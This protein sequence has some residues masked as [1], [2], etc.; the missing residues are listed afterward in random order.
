MTETPQAADEV[1]AR[2]PG[3]FK[4]RKAAFFTLRAADVQWHRVCDDLSGVVILPMM[5]FSPW[6]FGSTQRWAIECMTAAGYVLGVLLLVKLFIRKARGY[7][8]PRWENFSTRTGALTRRRHPVTRLLRR[9]LALLTLAVLGNCLISAWNAAA[10][11]NTV[12]GVFEYQHYL[13]WL[14]HS[15]DG[16]RTWFYFWM[17][18]GLAGSFW[19]VADW[20]AGMTLTEE[21][22][23]FAGA[24]GGTE[25][26]SLR[27]PARLRTLL[28]LLC[29]N[30]ALLGVEAIAQRASGSTKLLFLVQ[31]RVNPEGE[32]QFGPYAYR[33]NAAQYFNL[34]WPLCLGFWLTLQRAGSGRGWGRHGLLLCAAVMTACPV[35]ST[36]R[37]GALAAM[38]MLVLAMTGLAA[39]SLA[40]LGREGR[41]ARHWGTTGW[42]VLFLAGTI[43]LGWHYGWDSLF[44]RLEV[45]S[46]QYQIRADMYAAA[47][48]MAKDYPWFGTGP[49]TFGTVFQ[50]YRYSNEVYWPEQLH[51]DWLE[52]RITFGWLGLGLLLA[53]LAVVGLRWFAPGGMRGGRRLA[54]LGWLALGG[55]LAQA[56]VDF[57]FQ[58]HSTL[59][60]FLVIC[61]ILFNLS[62]HAGREHR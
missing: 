1:R 28:W 38:G 54:A 33:S 19:A 43:W 47:Q 31:P 24:R 53:A 27:L 6:A 55:C 14:P 2:E 18:L 46:E 20:L 26:T 4:A 15:L 11:Y 56:R 13:A 34:L 42:L 49:G 25:K 51:N 32:T 61:A 45:A 23:A 41:G 3:W 22:Q 7:P 50:L 21:R 57:P 62:E 52:T 60:L 58:I 8:A 5:V 36:S 12:T 39:G 9:V 48:P 29:L 17:Y 59:F 40:S 30:G 37:A 10:N 35:I 44:P 16:H